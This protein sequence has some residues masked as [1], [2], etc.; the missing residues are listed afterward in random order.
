[1]N[2]EQLENMSDK[3]FQ[4]YVDARNEKAAAEKEQKR[5]DYEELKTN[6]LVGLSLKAE[7]LSNDLKAFK[8]ESFDEMQTLYACLQEYSSRHN[9]DSKGNF[10]ISNDVY[11]TSYIKQG[12]GTFDERAFQAE[13][14]IIDFLEARYSGDKDTKDLIVSLLERK[15]GDLDINLIQKLYQ[16]EGRF[17]DENW[18]MGIQLLKESYK[19]Q[20]SKDY[21]KFEKKNK[22]GEW[23]PISLQFSKI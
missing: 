13:K 5:K 23:I 18:K 10:T 7:K 20:H 16:M 22:N 6:T 21:L 1:M 19:Y 4:E 12:K 11:K 9:E 15:K 2:K 3:E 17:Q 8:K 14:H